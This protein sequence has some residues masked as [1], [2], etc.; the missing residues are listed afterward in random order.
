MPRHNIVVKGIPVSGGVAMGEVQVLRDPMFQIVR[1]AV[2]ASGTKAEID[3]LEQ[4]SQQV[5]S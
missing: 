2:P 5:I 4:A 1:R 3:R